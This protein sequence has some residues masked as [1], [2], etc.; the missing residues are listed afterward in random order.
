MTPRLPRLGPDAPPRADVGRVCFADEVAIDFPSVHA[1]V[2]RMRDAFLGTPG[3]AHAAPPFRL[4]I[5]L[6]RTEAQ[7]G[8]DVRLVVPIR[9]TCAA[10]GGRGEVW[11]DRC[12]AC[13]GAGDALD[14]H[15]LCVA[16]P[17]GVR[18][19]A[20]VNLTV[21]PRHAPATRVELH[22]SVR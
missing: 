16:V 15:E 21:T 8:R 20:C 3:D 22:V 12:E 11:S 19:G 13:A 14:G 4:E 6:S 7:F 2:D 5:A 18:D 1:V 17:A 10:C 9:R